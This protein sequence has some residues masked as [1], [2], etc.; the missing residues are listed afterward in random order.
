M[1][2]VRHG[3]SNDQPFPGLRP[4][5][6]EDHAFFFGRRSQIASLYGL[7][8]RSRFVAVIGSSG[9]GKSS[10]TRAGLLPV[11]EEENEQ[12]RSGKW[13]WCSMRPG[14]APLA[15]LA[16]ALAQLADSRDVGGTTSDIRRHH[17]EYQLGRSSFGLAD[18]VSEAG[19]GADEKFVLV[20][21]Q[22]EEL[23]RYADRPSETEADRLR[24][25]TSR[26]EAK[27]FVELLMEGRRSA[28]RDI[29][30]L[31]T[32]RSDFI[33]ACSDFPG[34]PE[35]VSATQ[36]LVP[37]LELDQIEQI[38]TEPIKRAG[39]TIDPALVQQLLTDAQGE[40]DQ[41]PVLQ[42]CLLQLWQ[43]AGVVAS[44]P[45]EQAPAGDA[46]AEPGEGHPS[47]A[48]HIDPGCYVAVGKMSGALS[49]HAEKL[50]PKLREEAVGAVFR[51]LSDIKDG[52][53]IRRALSYAQLRD[54]CGVPDE[55]LR[56]IVDLFRADDCSFLVT[57]PAGIA[58]VTD[59][60]VIDI[61]HEALL[62]RWERIRGLPGAT[63]DAGDKMPIGWL[64]Q[65]QKDGRKYQMLLSMLDGD[66]RSNKVEG[67]ERHWDWWRKGSRTPKWAE[68]Y[69]GNFASVE[70]MLRRGLAYQRRS[71]WLTGSMAVAGGVLVLW[72]GYL[73]YRNHV[74]TAERATQQARADENR[75]LA[76]QNFAR[77]ISNAQA[78]LDRTLAAL[79]AGDMKIAAAVSMEEAAQAAV[80]NIQEAEGQSAVQSG[81]DPSPETLSLEIKLDNTATDILIRS[82]N[83]EDEARKRATRALQ[84]AEKLVVLQPNSDGAQGLLYETKFRSA[85]VLA[86]KQPQAALALYRE[87]REIAQ[88]LADKSPGDGERQYHL[89][90]S[91]V[92]IGEVFRDD[93][94]YGEARQQF[95]LALPIADKLA[96]DHP[97][98]PVW[99]AYAPNTMSK[100]AGVM[101]RQSPPDLD[102]ALQLYDAA[103][104]RQNGLAER[105][106][107][108]SV[109]ISN[110]ITTRRGRAEVLARKGEWAR[111]SAEFEEVVAGRETLVDADRN[112]MTSLEYLAMDYERAVSLL[113]GQLDAGAGEASLPTADLLNKAVTVE[114]KA[115]D[116]WLKLTKVDPKN[117]NW[118]KSLTESG[119][120]R[121]ALNLRL[122]AIKAPQE[123]ARQ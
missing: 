42:H 106:P 83:S 68:R 21:D 10:L 117:S 97:D 82:K 91:T 87:A 88:K 59:D 94:K 58:N 111:A 109:V 43:Q 112:N 27:R 116:A 120:R 38:I 53:A 66:R 3:L 121:D 62:R 25:A 95:E 56:R 46:P 52:R 2:W 99:A 28:D 35:A 48:R 72:V 90:F 16:D 93:Q 67:I 50:L 86:E 107:T 1:S 119:K 11:L 41:L 76:D 44:Q 23:F 92:K 17:I 14:D 37:G 30:V 113:F 8:D 74:D 84:L 60:T 123:A 89:A 80:N 33:G 20:V 47:L 19:V 32:M 64:A 34:L 79:N 70:D 118:Q 24:D 45:S 55:E 108:N 96:V 115:H 71:L 61:G 6:H 105:F 101:A 63:G 5:D 100:L 57:S 51:A 104:K 85:D 65:E 114:T 36:F 7:L 75:R 12:S 73:Q 77:S 15:S 4:F 9:S 102:R 122:D 39:A 31:I 110:R 13:A 22:F 26:S 29:R 103:L 78:F 81:F 49:V 69:G 18:A 54:E 40:P 98:N